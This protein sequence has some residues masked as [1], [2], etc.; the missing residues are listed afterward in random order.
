M[1]RGLGKGLGTLL[2]DALGAEEP[3][4]IR[5]VP[6]WQISMNP[7]QPRKTFDDERMGELVQ[8]VREHGIL[9]PLLV[10]RA[11]VDHYDLVAG[12]RRL[13]AALVLGL[14]SVPVVVKDY[15]DPQML[16]VALIENVQRE[17][18]TSVE[19]ALAY[20]QLIERFKFTQESIAERIG[21]ARSTVANTL[22]LL[23]LAEPVLESLTRGEISEGHARALLQVPKESQVTALQAMITLQMDVRHAERYARGLNQK[24]PLPQP[25]AKRE[26]LSQADPNLAAVEAAL[27]DVLGTKVT[28]KQSG[29]VGR[30]EIEF[31]DEQQLEGLVQR[32]TGG[33]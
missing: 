12:E 15:T 4:A 26:A 22:R 21:K 29:A 3:D 31:Y 2:G 25:K 14:P 30:I 6:P 33:L 8:S 1:R 5:N 17:D 9:Q 32:L 11:G 13:R 24:E 16:E 18:I 20:R 19:A 23:S 7:F 10:R 28:V 27:R